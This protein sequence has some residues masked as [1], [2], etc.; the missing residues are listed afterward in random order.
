MK[1]KF[2]STAVALVIGV[3]AFAQ[4][5]QIENAEKAFKSGDL[6][7]AK[8]LIDQIDITEKNYYTVDPELVSDFLFLKGNVNKEIGKTKNDDDALV[9]AA[10]AY[11]ELAKLE[12]G[13]SYSAKNKETGDYEF[14]ANQ[15]A[16]DTA[17]ATDGY[18][19]GK[20]KDIKDYHSAEVKPL[21]EEFAL[22]F[23]QAA[24]DAYNAQEYNKSSD[25]FVN[26]YRMYENPLVGRSDTTLLY[27]AAAVSISGDN[28]PKALVIYDELLKMDYTGITTIY[29]ATDIKSGEKQTFATQKDL[30]MQKKFGVVEND[31]SYVTKN[32]QP[33]IYRSVGS[34]Y[35]NMGDKLEDSDSLKKKEYYH[36]A[37]EV[38]EEGKNKYPGDYDMLLTLGNTYLKEGDQEGFIKTM[39][40][41]IAQ[42]P[43]N[44]VLYYNIGVVSADLG[45]KEEAK[46][47]YKK[48]IEIKPDYTDAYINMAALILS[49]E[50]E[51]NEEISALPIKLNKANRAK[52]ESLKK[53]KNGIYEEAIGYL[54]GAYEYDKTNEAL[55]QTMKNI[56]YALDRNEDFM[57]IKKE[58]D[59]LP[60]A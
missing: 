42:D 5:D 7:K 25:Y 28:Y 17:M 58:I 3:S 48:A 54:E 36:K 27:N 4:E 57:R 26:A 18:K 49:R 29:E 38:L 55:L 39:N 21:V 24:I 11:A 51:I 46:N 34:I 56:Y 45:M 16:Y 33:G 13:K 9:S 60:K 14:F 53:E 8:S 6:D 44:E 37:L 22:K 32:N 31:T 15:G 52:L 30:D 19:K 20:V 2:I 59:A 50:K 41:A 35:L 1:R 47:A 12:E 40:E 23:H 10:V 43:N